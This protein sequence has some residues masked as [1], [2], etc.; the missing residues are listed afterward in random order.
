MKVEYVNPFVSSGHRILEMVLQEKPTRDKLTALPSMFTSEQLNVTVGVTGAIQ[1]SVIYGMSLVT[2]D[3]IA[4]SM[5]GQPIKTFDQLAASAIA[6]LC[7][8]ISGNALILLSEAG[9]I[10][11][12]APPTLIR[13]SNTKISTMD[14]PAV[15]VPF[16]IS[17]G[18]FKITVGLKERALAKV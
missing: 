5:I 18:E 12:I 3:K 16:V 13:G 9:L 2:A 4:S 10:C 15:V 1:G 14:I 6:E 7:N 8:M 11:D 17:Q